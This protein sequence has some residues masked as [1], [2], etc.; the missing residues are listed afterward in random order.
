MKARDIIS[1]ITDQKLLPQLKTVGADTDILSLVPS[2]L[3][4][5]ERQLAV[6]EDDKILGVITEAS[7]LEG[8]GGIL[9]GRDDSILITL[10]TA[11]ADYSAS[12]I[13]RAVEDAD[14]HLVDLVTKPADDGMIKV[15]I[16]VRTDDPSS[17]VA[18]LERYDIDVVEVSARSSRFEDAVMERLL[19][20]N[21]I[22]NV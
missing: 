7:L 3:D 12:K 6:T 16:R 19:S 5:T 13:A 8:L 21:A 1:H 15:T 14:V 2:L 11:P 18:N 4:T 20:L 10:Q 9:A 22:L 17:V